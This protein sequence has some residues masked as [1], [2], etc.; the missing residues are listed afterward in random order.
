M[1]LYVWLVPVLLWLFLVGAAVGSFLNVC[2]YRIP[3]GK[4]LTWPGSR[5][6]HC[7]HEVRLKDNIPLV[8]YWML[9]GRCRDCGAAFSM[10][11]FWVELLTALLFPGLFLL[12]VA[13]N[14]QHLPVWPNGGFAF[15]QW[16]RSPP[17]WGALFVPHAVFACFLIVAAGCLCDHGR[18]PTS[19]AVTGSLAGLLAAVLLPWPFPLEPAAVLA[20]PPDSTALQVYFPVD[21]GPPGHSLRGAMPADASWSIWPASPRPGF[22]PWPV[23]GPIPAWL[24]P[25]SWQLGLATGLAGALVGAWA[26]R[27]AGW[28]TR[29]T[30]GREVMPGGAA[31]LAMMAGAFLG[32][33]PVLVALVL[34]LVF[35]PLLYRWRRRFPAFGPSLLLGIVAAW[36]G[37]AWLGPMVRPI[38]FSPLL[39][40]T[41]LATALVLAGVLAVGKRLKREKR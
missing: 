22:Y 36:L 37:W 7:L 17:L 14:V 41:A 21:D 10:R 19:V 5:C 2:I 25:G 40:A 27:L 18:V 4:S 3:L 12:E 13:L 28:G 34:A 32:W 15:L 38:L 31:S 24:P 11:Y 30:L 23:W 16:G 29:T 8:S 9:R 26:L 20:P 1:L 39:L 33:Q 35:A 6:G